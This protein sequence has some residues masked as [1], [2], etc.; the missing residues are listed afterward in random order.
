MIARTLILYIR[1]RLDSGKVDG[2][3]NDAYDYLLKLLIIGDANSNK[4]MFINKFIGN[5]S[6]G[7]GS[8]TYGILYQAINIT[9]FTLLILL[10]K[11]LDYRLKDVQRN[12]RKI[13]LQLW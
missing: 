2:N 3:M 5:A 7:A 8:S 10:Y 6:V 11:G 13:K 1:S 4:Q 9:L 12:G